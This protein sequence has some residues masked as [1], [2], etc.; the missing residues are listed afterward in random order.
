MKGVRPAGHAGGA[1]PLGPREAG[2]KESNRC[3]GA[4]TR[5]GALSLAVKVAPMPN[6]RIPAP[7]VRPCRRPSFVAKILRKWQ[8]TNRCGQ[9]WQVSQIHLWLNVFDI[10]A[11]RG[12][13]QIQ[14]SL[15]TFKIDD[16]AFI[17]LDHQTFLPLMKV[18]PAGFALS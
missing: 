18:R 16:H 8:T 14:A 4:V 12:Q 15:M 10:Q 13:I 6:L 1:C 5:S 11:S 7:G 2:K 17:V 3:P 9:T